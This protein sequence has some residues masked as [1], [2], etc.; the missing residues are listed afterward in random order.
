MRI[1]IFSEGGALIAGNVPLVN[2]EG[3][4][5]NFRDLSLLRDGVETKVQIWG[6][7]LLSRL[8]EATL[9]LRP[10]DPL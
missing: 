8:A 10:P 9:K 5:S 2:R 4:L 3:L 6:W 7:K 1:E